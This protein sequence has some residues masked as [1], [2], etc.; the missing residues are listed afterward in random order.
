MTAQQSQRRASIAARLARLS[1]KC[2]ATGCHIWIGGTSGSTGRGAGYPRMKLDGRTVAAH[3]VAATL[4]HG[5]IH[6]G[7]QVDHTCR[8]RLCV[9]PDHLEVVSPSENQR[10]RWA[11]TKTGGDDT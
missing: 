9:N 2:P 1:R 11:V 8:N 3:R 5:Y 10:R 4:A 7:Q 6:P